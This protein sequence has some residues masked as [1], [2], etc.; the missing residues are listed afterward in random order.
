M[1][2]TETICHY[3]KMLEQHQIDFDLKMKHFDD[4][5]QRQE[6]TWDQHRSLE[7]LQVDRNSF[8]VMRE[9]IS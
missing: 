4:L 2:R 8:R 5:R 7:L 9:I 6:D 3:L 1:K